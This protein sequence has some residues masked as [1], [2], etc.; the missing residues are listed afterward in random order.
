M[1]KFITQ[2][3]RV[4]MKNELGAIVAY[5]DFPEIEGVIHITHTYVDDS[6]R[7]Q[8]IAGKLMEQAY[9]KIKTDGRKCLADCSYAQHWFEKHPEKQDILA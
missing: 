7:G 5:I 3:N 4:I 1:D 6:L 2:D 8:G 9:E